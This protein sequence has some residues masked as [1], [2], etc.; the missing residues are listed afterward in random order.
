MS[1]PERQ[2]T[3]GGGVARLIAWGRIGNLN[4]SADLR[5]DGDPEV[6]R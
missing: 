3:P 1:R 4:S 6:R 5:G 2:T